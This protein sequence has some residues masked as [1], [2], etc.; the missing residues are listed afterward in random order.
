M[1]RDADL[2]ADLVEGVR[3]FVRE[4]LIP[5]ESVVA[6]NDQIPESIVTEMREL[7]LFGL[8]I[9][10][11]YGGIGLT[12]EEEVLVAFE[13]G[14]ASPC[15]R[16]LVG[17][18]NGIGSLSLVT[19]GTEAQKRAWLPRLATGEV[20]ASFA[21]TEPDAGSDAASLRT[22]AR[23]DGDWVIN[24]TKR[25]ITNA[26]EA[27]L[28]TVFARTR[29]DQKGS[30]GISAFL[31]PRDTPGVVIGKHD[32]KMGQRGAHTA[33]VIFDD[34][35][36]SPDALLG[37]E[38]EGFRAA[39]RTLDRGRLHISAICVALSE[40]LIAEAVNYANTRKQFGKPIAE[41]QLIQAMLADS[42]VEAY[43]ARCMVLETARARDSGE[44]V[45][46]RASCCKLFASE[47]LG[48]IADRAV[49]VHGGAG[50]MQ[51]T[52][53]ERLY[54][55]ARLY[56]IYEGTSQIQ[57]LIIARRLLAEAAVN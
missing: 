31:V 48:R 50:Y 18:N 44:D 3:R 2:L 39:M 55:D 47:A 28:F 32:K 41:F 26:P 4:R 36:V 34:C 43:A 16:S 40:R 29:P 52:A 56:R 1:I 35:R 27:K 46:E 42:R 12:T 38:G 10:E 7:G 11:E 24:G 20:I 19:D 45:G 5:I 14:H 25:F 54:R 22:S 13:L 53:V 57:Q 23:L 51:E 21:L 15:F 49:Q 33:D 6:E 17:T 37:I 30:K 8:T 9:P